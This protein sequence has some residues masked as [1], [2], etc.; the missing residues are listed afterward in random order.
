MDTKESLR[1]YVYDY[2]FEQQGWRCCICNTQAM[3]QR[4]S[5]DHCHKTGKIRGLLCD[6][7]NKGLGMFQDNPAM[8]E[9]AITYLKNRQDRV[10]DWDYAQIS[11]HS[12]RSVN[13]LDLYDLQF[14]EATKWKY[15]NNK[16]LDLI[17]KYTDWK[18][19]EVQVVCNTNV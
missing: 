3:R 17:D 2:L 8:L 13:K 6:M 15:A 9:A 11:N 1:E 4:L 5:I 19:D 7:C 12:E 16:T 18:H 14:H 10:P